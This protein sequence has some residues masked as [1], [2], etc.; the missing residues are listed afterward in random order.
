[1]PSLGAYRYLEVVWTNQCKTLSLLCIQLST[2]ATR[3]HIIMKPNLGQRPPSVLFNIYTFCKGFM[4]NNCTK[5]LTLSYG[6]GTECNVLRLKESTQFS[7]PNFYFPSKRDQNSN[8]TSCID[9]IE[10]RLCFK[11]WI[12]LSMESV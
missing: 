11:M 4:A 10:V 8:W 6:C 3:S 9:G 7:W 1:M 2:E 12:P 5:R